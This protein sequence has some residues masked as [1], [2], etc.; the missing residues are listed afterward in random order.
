MMDI[1]EFMFFFVNIYAIYNTVYVWK[2]LLKGKWGITVEQNYRDWHESILHRKDYE[3]A[4][5]DS[6]FVFFG[7]ILYPLI[8]API[9]LRHFGNTS[10][11]QLL[12]RWVINLAVFSGLFSMMLMAR[13]IWLGFQYRK[14]YSTYSGSFEPNY[15][16]IV[17]PG[18]RT[19]STEEHKDHEQKGCV[20]LYGGHYVGFIVTAAFTILNSWF[21][22]VFFKAVLH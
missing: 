13:S 7:K 3:S 11:L 4:W 14:Y 19:H 9:F 17:N 18:V 6:F 20:L 16:G 21:L 10:E 8:I 1:W 12:T 22:V 15:L 5:I 2:R